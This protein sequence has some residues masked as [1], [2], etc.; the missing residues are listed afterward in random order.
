MGT[1]TACGLPKATERGADV[2]KRL[3]APAKKADA[4]YPATDPD[5]EEEAITWH[6]ADAL[7]LKDIRRVTY[8]EITE[9]AV[10]AA[11]QA[12]RS[13]NMALVPLRKGG[14]FW[15]V[16]AGIWSPARFPVPWA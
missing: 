14:A 8:G 9:S 3:T 10:K 11:V 15:I 16:C 5:R 2:L 1:M 7:A 6:I 12:P 13:I 4:V